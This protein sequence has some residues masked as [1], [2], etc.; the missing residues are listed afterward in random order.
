MDVLR[1]T[2]NKDRVGTKLKLSHEIWP[3]QFIVE[4]LSMAVKGGGHNSKQGRKQ[5]IKRKFDG[6]KFRDKLT[7]VPNLSFS[8][9]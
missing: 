1:P 5:G 2:F 8:L 6:M 3:W 7:F 4:R 9:E